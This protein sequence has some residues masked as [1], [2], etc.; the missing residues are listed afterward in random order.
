MASHP[1]PV[2]P[3]LTIWTRHYGKVYQYPAITTRQRYAPYPSR[4][5]A[6]DPSSPRS[7]IFPG[8]FTSTIQQILPTTP[9]TANTSETVN[10]ASRVPQTSQPA[11][12]NNQTATE[13]TQELRP[14]VENNGLIKKP[15]G[16]A[17]RKKDGRGY[18]IEN[19]LKWPEQDMDNLKVRNRTV[20]IPR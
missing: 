14:A 10:S 19:T 5:D 16:E 20:F 12:P 9:G 4:T 2:L 18:N 1:N 8:S 11:A 15:L 7:P 6:P 17:G 3:V 13:T